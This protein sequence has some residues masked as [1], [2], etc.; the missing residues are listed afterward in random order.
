[1]LP[2]STGL[3]SYMNSL[4]PVVHILTHINMQKEDEE[5]MLQIMLPQNYKYTF[6]KYE[7]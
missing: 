4:L 7:L 6:V 2:A 1:M 3:M 5:N